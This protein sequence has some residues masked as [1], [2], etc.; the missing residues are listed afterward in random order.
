MLTLTRAGVAFVMC[1]LVLAVCFP[2]AARADLQQAAGATTF[3]QAGD[4]ATRTLLQ[5]FYAGGGLWRDCNTAGCQTSNSDWGDDAATYTLYLRW[6]AGH[7]ATIPPVMRDLSKTAPLYPAPCSDTVGCSSWSDTPEWDAV[8]LM[9][10]YDVLGDRN[11]LVRAEDAFRFVDQSHAYALGACPVIPY[12]QP[13]QTTD[14]KTLETLSNSIKAAMLI[15]G[16]THDTNYLQSAILQY[17][18]ARMYFLDAQVPL[19]SVHVIDDGT[20]CRQ[21]A[22]RFFASVNGN[23]IWN[24]IA[25]WRATGKPGYYDQ[26]LATAHAA[27]ADLA[28]GRMIFADVQG[29]ND[30]VE[31]L[32]EAMYELAVNEHQPFA[33]EWILRNAAAAL[34]ARAPDGTFSRFFDGPPEMKTSI[35]E[36]NG[37]FALEIAASALD[38]NRQVAVGNGWSAATF[39]GTPST[40]LPATITF[41]GS[42]VALVGTVGPACESSHIRVLVD[43]RQTFDQ[44]GLWQNKRMPDGNRR[45]VLFAWRW[46][47]SGEHTITLEPGAAN[48]ALDVR[49]YVAGLERDPGT[50]ATQSIDEAGDAHARRHANSRQL[51]ARVHARTLVN[52]IGREGKHDALAVEHGRRV[53]IQRS[54][55]IGIRHRKDAGKRT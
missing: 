34:A 29:D 17:A 3:A 31:P 53:T 21:V 1:A 2:H 18:A 25:L 23:M 8:A 42:G 11:A 51:V 16:A 47:A 33:R 22:H 52:G 4:E 30:V 46:S 13:A 7:D 44:T 43:G 32:V 10:E 54:P 36:S 41:D 55:R 38:P 20:Q 39:F 19:Y 12:Q 14:L 24:G 28:D 45:I 37:G 15:Y 5:S 26:A 35:W 49:A 40:T 27:D 6:I 9:R 48:A 50:I